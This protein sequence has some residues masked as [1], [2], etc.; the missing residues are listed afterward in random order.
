MQGF[1]DV[2]GQRKINDLHDNGLMR[3]G[4]DKPYRE[5]RATCSV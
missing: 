2:G 4:L 5:W 1:D 3:G